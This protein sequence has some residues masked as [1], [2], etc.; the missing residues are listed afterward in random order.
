VSLVRRVIFAGRFGPA[1]AVKLRKAYVSCDYCL[2]FSQVNAVSTI[3]ELP[4][5]RAPPDDHDFVFA[6]E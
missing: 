5:D 2:D 4:V 1:V 3:Q 6:A